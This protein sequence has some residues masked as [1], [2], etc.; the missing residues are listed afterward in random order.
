MATNR[1]SIMNVD[2]NKEKLDLL[3]QAAPG[4]ITEAYLQIRAKR[5]AAEEEVKRH[6]ATLELMQ[7]V[8]FEK[9]AALKQDGFTAHGT[10]VYKYDLITH[11]VPD[12]TALRELILSDPENN[13]ELIEMRASKSGVENYMANHAVIDTKGN[14]VTPPPNGVE[15]VK[16]LKLGVRKK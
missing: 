4:T 3:R 8:I 2:D 10:T 1:R 13:L 9:M 12:P 7:V 14:N 11:R 16:H 15:I 5:D 6:G